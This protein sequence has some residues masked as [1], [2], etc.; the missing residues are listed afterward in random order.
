MVKL[1]LAYHPQLEATDVW[2]ATPLI[3]AA[4]SGEPEV[5]QLLVS[6]GA[7]LAARSKEGETPLRLAK[8]SGHQEAVQLLRRLGATEK[9]GALPGWDVGNN[10]LRHTTR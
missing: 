8:A 9:G 2:A 4:R 3:E 1:L 5:I 7:N 6:Q 10:R